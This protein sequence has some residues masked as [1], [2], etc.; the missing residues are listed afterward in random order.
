MLG[1]VLLQAGQAGGGSIGTIVLFGGMFVIMYFF[2]IRPQ[3]KKAKEQKL[4]RESLKKGDNV[5]TI[6]GLHGKIS[7]IEADDTIIVEVDKGIK[8]KFDRGSISAE[9]SK[10][11]NTT[12][13][14]EVNLQK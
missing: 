4:F 1:L 5:V 2:M 3:Q 11:V 6:G 12:P 13:S 14:A 10:R 7:S 9:A 8:L